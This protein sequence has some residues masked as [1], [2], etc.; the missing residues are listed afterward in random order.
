MTSPPINF[1]EHDLQQLTYNAK[2]RTTPVIFMLKQENQQG[3][4]AESQVIADKVRMLIDA[5]VKKARYEKPT[6]VLFHFLEESGYLTYLTKQEEQ[7]DRESIRQIYH[8]KQFFDLI[9]QYEQT[10]PSAD[11]VGFLQFFEQVLDSGDTGKLY[12]PLDTPD[13][14][15]IM[16]VHGSKGLEFKYVFVVNLV[17]GRFPT[18]R[19]GGDIEIPEELIH[20]ILPEGDAHYQEERRLFY[21]AVTRA[22]HHLYLMSA[23]NYGGARNTKLSRFLAELDYQTPEEQ[24]A[25]PTGT[26]L[27]TK[28]A[29]AE[30][31]GE[32]QY[33]LPKTF[34]FSQIKTFENSPYQYKLEHILKIPQKGSPY[35]SFGNSM[36]NTLQKFYQQIQELNSAQQGSLFGLVEEPNSVESNIKVPPLEDLLELYEQSFIEEWYESE[37]QKN[38]YYDQGKKML[39][40]YYA[41]QDGAWRIPVAIESGLNI[42]MGSYTIRGKIDRID[43]LEDGTLE[44]ID[45]KT[46]TPKDKITGADKD[47]L[48]LYQIA[49]ETM[50]IYQNIGKPSKLTYHYLENN[51]PL[52]FFGKDKEKEKLEDKIIKLI[53]EIHATDWSK[54]TSEHQ[55]YFGKKYV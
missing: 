16:T 8:L 9:G 3:I 6:A 44:I 53:D 41:S 46:G 25:K 47:Q 30:Q 18:R 5:G 37:K 20:E 2:R 51:S 38:G 14:V 23:D 36:H 42:K 28:P 29:K 35:F 7:G 50:P 39:R 43:Q 33:K 15:N 52:S 48:L 27:P 32:F 54:I 10:H 34:S 12:Q 17:E 55:G 45:Y 22:K 13:S 40:A 31:T 24:A 26:V 19:R 4:K 11:V 21:V 1:P 49:A